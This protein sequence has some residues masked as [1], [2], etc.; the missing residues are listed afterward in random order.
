MLQPPTTV[1]DCDVII[2][3]PCDVCCELFDTEPK[4]CDH[5][6][7][8]HIGGE[9]ETRE[10]LPAAVVDCDVIIRHPCDVCCELFDT[11]PELCDHL[12]VHIDENETRENLPDG[13]IPETDVP[14]DN[15]MPCRSQQ[16]KHLLP[17]G[18]PK[19]YKCTVYAYSCQRKHAIVRHFRCHTGEKPYRCEVCNCATRDLSTFYAHIRKKHPTFKPLKCC[20]CADAF[21]VPT[22]LRRHLRSHTGEQTQN[23]RLQQWIFCDYEKGFKSALYGHNRSKHRYTDSEPLKCTVCAQAFVTQRQLRTHLRCHSDER[24]RK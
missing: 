24:Q 12:L 9:K 2:R 13:R 23:T 20:V 14:T 3:H 15:A 21:L 11:E 10:N 16:D 1:F 18:G 7:Q 8:V 5:L 19:P 6:R 17:Q 22:H 4:L